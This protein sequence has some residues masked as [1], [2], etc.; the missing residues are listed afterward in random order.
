MQYK[1]FMGNQAYSSWSLRGWLLLKAFGFDFEYEVVP[2]FSPEWERFKAAH[3]PAA[4]V[5]TLQ[6]YDD[7]ARFF[8][9]DSLAIAEFL[10]EQDPGAGIWP[11]GLQ[12]RAAARTLCAEMH[13]SFFALRANM[14]MNVRREFR[15]VTPDGETR[16]DIDRIEDLWAWVRSTGT[17]AGPYLFGERLCAAD[18]FFAPVA[19]RFRTYRVALRP[20]SQGYVDALLEHPATLEFYAAGRR[21]SWIIE[22]VE[23]DQA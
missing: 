6:V 3:F 8:V 17:G 23:F 10:H 9:W 16:A 4:T 13:S 21:E 15:T 20:E 2:L 22:K 7:S 19:S 18:A 12:A 11:D 14:P 1:L 5:P